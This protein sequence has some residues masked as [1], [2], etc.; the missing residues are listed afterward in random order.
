MVR[1]LIL[2]DLA[3][4]D[5]LQGMHRSNVDHRDAHDHYLLGFLWYVRS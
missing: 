5:D 2:V 1:L 4:C 3:L